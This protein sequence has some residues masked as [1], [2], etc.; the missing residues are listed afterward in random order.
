MKPFLPSRRGE[1]P[2]E[3][4]SPSTPWRAAFVRCGEKYFTCKH[5]ENAYR[6]SSKPRT[7]VNKMIEDQLSEDRVYGRATA[8]QSKRELRLLHGLGALVYVDM[9]A[10]IHTWFLVGQSNQ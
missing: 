2:L 6:K 4:S 7:S 8:E 3:G 1:I 5:I 10:Y 9:H